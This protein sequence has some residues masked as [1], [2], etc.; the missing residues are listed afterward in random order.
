MGF[1][2]PAQ[3]VGCSSGR[4][5]TGFLRCNISAVKPC[6]KS[7]SC[8]LISKCDIT[9]L[10]SLH[11]A[12]CGTERSFVQCKTRWDKG[13]D[14]VCLVTPK[15]PW[16]NIPVQFPIW[17]TEKEKRLQNHTG[18]SKYDG[19]KDGSGIKTGSRYSSP[20][21]QSPEAVCWLPVCCL[22][23]RGRSLRFCLSKHIQSGPVFL[24]NCS[25]SAPMF[26][27]L[28][29]MCGPLWVW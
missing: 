16:E 20:K 8:T 4:T 26:P 21:L 13:G 22:T 7:A 23:R 15:K 27:S 19:D 10:S 12:C 2:V 1:R 17:S 29:W 11:K 18:E 6:A 9:N 5:G 24:T 25:L 3:D 28:S 14:G